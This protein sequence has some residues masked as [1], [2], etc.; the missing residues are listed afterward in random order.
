V[1]AIIL[2]GGL[3]KRLRSVVPSLPKPMAP[4]KGKPFLCYLLDYWLQQGIKHFILSVGYKHEI[5]RE[6]FGTKYKNADVNYAIEKEP[7]GTGGGLF[8]AIKQLRS[9]E[10]FLLLNGDTFF[11]INLNNLFNYH[12]NCKSDITLSLIETKN[13]KRYGGVLLDKHGMVSSIYSPKDSFKT[14]MANGGVYIMKSALFSKYP[15]KIFEKC[16][17]EEELLPQLLMQKQRIAG[18]VSKDSFVDIGILHDYTLAADIL[19]QHM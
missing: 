13:D 1:E 15:K 12:Q 3:G 17:L 5:I 4:I 2:A 9:T 6:K 18:F 8:L 7:L 11:A 10:P 19:S 14:S 16:S